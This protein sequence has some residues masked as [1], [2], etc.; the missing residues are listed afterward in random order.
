MNNEKITKDLKEIL[1]SYP[2]Q[3]GVGKSKN[4][5]DILSSLWNNGSRLIDLGCSFP[6]K[7]TDLINT[8]IED[9]EDIVLCQQL[10][11]NDGE[12]F[13]KYGTH[14]YEM[15][16]EQ[17]K[18]VIDNIIQEQL[19]SNNVEFYHIYLIHSIFST[20]FFDN[21]VD[22]INLY[23]RIFN[24]LKSY[25]E[26][27]IFQHLGFSASIDYNLLSTFIFKLQSV[28]LIEHID[29]AMVSYNILSYNVNA[30]RQNY[31]IDVWD[32]PDIKGLRLLK[33]NN[34]TVICMTPFERGKVLEII[35]KCPEMGYTLDNITYDTYSYILNCKYIDY[36]L[37]G[38][39]SLNH[40]EEIYSTYKT[41]S[42]IKTMEGSR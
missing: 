41:F 27:G 5:K 12:I 10:P 9:K 20:R 4:K 28:G 25:K 7:N 33:D 6:G 32:S 1:G 22:D 34:F 21:I 24:I 3:I 15:D 29:V 19:S 13:N 37:I 11:L 2:Y 38:T 8:F 42:A 36:I 23:I 26:K 31:N 14:I 16:E 39:S 35:N 40:L 18:L 30:I 17:L